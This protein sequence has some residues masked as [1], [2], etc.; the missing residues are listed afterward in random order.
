MRG[1]GFTMVTSTFFL[2]DGTRSQ[3]V[4][5]MGEQRFADVVAALKH[6]SFLAKSGK[7]FSQ[8]DAVTV[9]SAVGLDTELVPAALE[10]LASTGVLES[11]CRNGATAYYMP[12]GARI[13]YGESIGRPPRT[14]GWDFSGTRT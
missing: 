12:R 8:D 14:S 7:R 2:D 11:Y 6:L 10:D 13:E 5:E 9:L 1:K 3:L 4:S